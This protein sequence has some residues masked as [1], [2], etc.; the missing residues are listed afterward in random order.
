MA[1]GIRE[2]LGADV[3]VATTGVAGPEPVDDVPVGTLVW[4]V[5]TADGVRSWTRQLPGDR[6]QVRRRLAAAAIEALRRAPT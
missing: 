2:R 5:A 1:Q 3:G 4:A 6:Q